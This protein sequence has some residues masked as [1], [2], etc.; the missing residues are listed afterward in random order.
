MSKLSE[1]TLS[2]GE[3]HAALRYDPDAGLFFR[4]LKHGREKPAGSKQG[5]YRGDDYVSLLVK[6]HQYTAHALAWFYVHGKKRDD[7]YH[8]NGNKLDNRIANLA[9]PDR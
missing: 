5:G 1:T 3:L 7:V 8:L 2:Q 9:V 4:P 6:G